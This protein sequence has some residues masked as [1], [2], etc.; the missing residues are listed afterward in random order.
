MQKFS[1]YED[2]MMIGSTIFFDLLS[3]Y[4]VRYFK[5]NMELL[6]LSFIFNFLNDFLVN[7]IMNFYFIIEFNVKKALI[8]L[9]QFKY[10]FLNYLYIF[11]YYK[12]Y[13]IYNKN[14]SKLYLEV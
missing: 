12:F 6:Q 10:F 9:K 4:F 14:Y 3:F 5:N 7:V 11:D 1:V 13:N 8:Q 2:K